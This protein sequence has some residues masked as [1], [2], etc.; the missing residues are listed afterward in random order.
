MHLELFYK[1]LPVMYILI[2][3]RPHPGGFYIGTTTLLTICAFV[4][5]ERRDTMKAFLAGKL[6]LI[7]AT[8]IMGRGLDLVRV[9]QVIVFD[10]PSS[11]PEYIHEIGRASRLGN[12]GSAMVFINDDDKAIFKE[13]VALLQSTSTVIPRELSNSPFLHSSYAVA[14][15]KH[16]RK[17]R[18]HE[19]DLSD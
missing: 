3:T 9:T 18:K 16:K 6:P 10:M 1:A 14:Y 4:S 5:Q 2:N 11:I 13:F 12:P 15:S 7:V 17:R 8:G 19:V